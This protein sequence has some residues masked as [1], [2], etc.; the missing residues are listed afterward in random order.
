M[1]RV[2]ALRL[3]ADVGG[4]HA[5]FALL[6]GEGRPGRTVALPSARFDGLE[7]AVAAALEALGRP[8]SELAGG[9]MAV[10]VAGPVVGDRIEL[11]NAAWS[12]ALDAT[13]RAL[14]LRSLVALND[15]EALALALPRLAGDDLEVWREGEGNANAPRALLGPGTGLGVGGLVRTDGEWIPVPSEG[16]HRD[17]APTTEREWLATRRLADERGRLGAEDVLSGPGLAALDAALREV[18]GLGLERRSAEEVSALARAGADSHAVES[19]RMFSAL[20]G[21]VAGDLALTFGA[22]GGVYLAGGVLEGLGRAFDRAGFLARFDGKGR[23]SGYVAAIPVAR[24]VAPDASLRGAAS[25][26]DPP[27]G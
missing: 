5:R 4:T 8:V 18:D 7:P 3:V 11:T 10:A 9:A 2:G 22:R 15:F 14:G 16:G 12:F 6:G 24:I 19:V 26:L 17:L 23:M 1:S 27:T 13:R 25:R 21:A 20:L